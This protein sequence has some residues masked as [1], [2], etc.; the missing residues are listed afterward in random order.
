MWN[1]L[2]REAPE[3]TQRLEFLDGLRGWAALVVLLVHALAAFPVIDMTALYGHYWWPFSGMFAVGVFFLVSGFALSVGYYRT[4][5]RI[6]VWRMGA[7]RYFRLMIPIFATCAIVSVLLNADLIMPSRPEGFRGIYEF[8]PTAA[9]LLRFGL[10]EVFFRYGQA[11]TYAGPLWTMSYELL[12]SALVLGLLILGGRRRWPPYVAF[13]L[14]ILA[15]Q[16]LYALFFAGMACAREVERLRSVPNWLGACLLLAGIVAWRFSDDLVWVA[17]TA[18]FVGAIAT[19][20]VLRFLSNRPSRILGHISFPLYLLHGPMVFAVGLPLYVAGS[21]WLAFVGTSISSVV[22]AIAFMPV[23]SF[24]M[25]ASRAFG[26][27]AVGLAHR[28]DGSRMEGVRP[29][30]VAGVDGAPV[31]PNQAQE[32]SRPATDRLSQGL[33]TTR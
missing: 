33:S 23:N 16:Y 19:P 29:R 31:S 8:D 7:G 10:F 5:D 12:G 6:A 24:A 32:P 14:A 25:R 22:A 17:A 21:P 18:F 9:H 13:A 20:G 28:I 11:D 4:G 30:G 26:G 2:A 1:S 15:G 3:L 27:L